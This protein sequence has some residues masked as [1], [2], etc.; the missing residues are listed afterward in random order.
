[1]TS[2]HSRDCCAGGELRRRSR[3]QAQAEI[4]VARAGSVRLARFIEPVLGILADRLE[5]PVAAGL[6]LQA[7]ERF[8][9]QRG[10]EFQHVCDVEPRSGADSFGPLQRPAAG[11]HGESPEQRALYQ[12]QQIVAPVDQRAQRLLARRCCSA[13]LRQQPEAIVEPFGNRLH[14]QRAQ[15][16][17][18][19]LDGERDAVEA[20][21]D[22]DHRVR[23]PL[24]QG[25]GGLHRDRTLDE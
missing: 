10:Q 22:L 16:R 21:T 18:G 7:D 1:M 14:R 2:S 19:E 3:A 9:D 23:V 11:K 15:P 12:V 17:G 6:G 25:E 24:A 13:A 4:E 8:L 20:A 5:R